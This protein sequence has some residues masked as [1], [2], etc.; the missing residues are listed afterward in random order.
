[1][2]L[3]VPRRVYHA[4]TPDDDEL[5]RRMRSGDEAA[6]EWLAERSYPMCL[7]FA[8][9][10]LG[11]REDAE[12]VVQDAMLRAYRA[13]RRGH[14]PDRFRP[15]LLGIVL[16]RCRSTI[17][18]RARRRKLSRLWLAREEQEGRRVSS[19]PDGPEEVDPALLAAVASLTP[20]L[21]E[22]FLLKHVEELT[23]DE[24]AEVTG[25]GVSALKMRVKRAADLL[26]Q[27]LTEE[28]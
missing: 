2:T 24:M 21:R 22:A 4:V 8:E 23:Y 25:V 27:R 12:E 6:F 7:R 14:L 16:N 13:L 15:W 11:R 5:V 26:L 10:H 19:P 17:A 20:R 28:A 1:M 9:R 3:S 18:R